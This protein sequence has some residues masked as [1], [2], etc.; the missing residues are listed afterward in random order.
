MN[1]YPK[2]K[3]PEFKLKP[4]PIALCLLI[5][6]IISGF[7]ISLNFFNAEDGTNINS[8]KGVITCIVTSLLSI[9]LTFAAAAKYRF[10]HLWKKNTSHERHRMH[11]DN[12]PK[13]ND[14]L[15]KKDFNNN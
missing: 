10:Q 12:H 9:F 13:K 3:V 7:L 6:I 2:G 4:D 5:I 1:V 8:Q 11:T 15:Y 14:D